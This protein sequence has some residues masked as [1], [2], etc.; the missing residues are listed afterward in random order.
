MPV[1]PQRITPENFARYGRVARLPESAPTAED[2]TFR[3]WSD[4]AHYEINGETE[5]GFCTVYRQDQPAVTWMER[6]DRTPELLIPIDGPF[7]LPVME[8]S[9]AGVEVFEVQPGE[10]VV[11]GQGVWHSA[12]HPAGGDAVT[13]FV[14]FRR[15]TPQEDVTKKD[16]PA[17]PVTP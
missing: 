2:A 7:L 17:T 1:T 3:Y 8:E 6:H 11:I 10:A 12:C 14:L 15:G 13:Y 16:L 5:I 9:G 4:A